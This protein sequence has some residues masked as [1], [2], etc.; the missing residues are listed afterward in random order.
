M[1]T[2]NGI[3]EDD[4]R[5]RNGWVGVW[6]FGAVLAG[7]QSEGV[8]F[9]IRDQRV[10]A[11]VGLRVDW[12]RDFG[13][14]GPLGAEPSNLGAYY[15]ERGELEFRLFRVTNVSEESREI[16]PSV[17][18]RGTAL[19]LSQVY[20]GMCARTLFSCDPL[21]FHPLP[22][23][24]SSYRSAFDLAGAEFAFDSGGKE[25]IPIDPGER[26]LKPVSIRSGESAVLAFRLRLR[27]EFP[28]IS[29]EPN[30]GTSFAGRAF[31]PPGLRVDPAEPPEMRTEGLFG[32]SA[33]I[34]LEA[35]LLVRN[36]V[37][38]ELNPI[39]LEN[40]EAG[41][42]LF[43]EGAT[44]MKAVFPPPKVAREINGLAVQI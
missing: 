32:V 19:E 3:E 43:T 4:M 28:L 41:I 39:Y 2:G 6:I 5:I 36:P 16:Y 42:N 31:R 37:T 24:L 40:P 10:A 11:Q 15:T 14:A 26:N 27:P 34:R 33:R 1:G 8:K 29:S 9:Q 44:S 18:R 30:V 20:W 21:V 13:R 25:S 7:C 38:D 23:S 12:I 22:D 17:L 35:R